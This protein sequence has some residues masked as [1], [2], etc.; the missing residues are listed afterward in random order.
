MLSIQSLFLS[1]M[2][3][4]CSFQ[5]NIK[6]AKLWSLFESEKRNIENCQILNENFPLFRLNLLILISWWSEADSLQG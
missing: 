2:N 5:L 4:I 1:G 6:N 3:V